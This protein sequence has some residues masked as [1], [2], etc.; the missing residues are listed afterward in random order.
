M[1]IY[2]YHQAT[3]KQVLRGQINHEVKFI[4]IQV[5]SKMASECYGCLK[6]LNV[7]NTISNSIAQLNL[8]QIRM[9]NNIFFLC[10]TI[11]KGKTYFDSW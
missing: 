1:I 11:N 10:N 8:M 9:H 3:E 6:I 7:L 5:S 4:A 2:L